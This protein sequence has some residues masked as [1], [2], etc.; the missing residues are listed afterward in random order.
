MCFQIFFFQSCWKLFEVWYPSDCWLTLSMFSS[1]ITPLVINIIH[2]I[3]HV[4]IIHNITLKSYLFVWA[5]VR[6][7][8][9]FCWF[10]WTQFVSKW[11]VA[12]QFWTIYFFIKRSWGRKFV[13]KGTPWHPRTFNP[14]H[15]H[16]TLVL[17]FTVIMASNF[18]NHHH[19]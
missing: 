2:D 4:N 7:F 12:L 15:L 8:S 13:G 5:S 11:F 18:T 6:G 19:S 10:V 16:V 1:S 17:T 14:L 3:I 9:K